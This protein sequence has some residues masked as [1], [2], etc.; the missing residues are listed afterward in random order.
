LEDLSDSDDAT[1]EQD[2]TSADCLNSGNR[3]RGETLST[4]AAS[5]VCDTRRDLSSDSEVDLAERND[6]AETQ[7][8]G[9]QI[10]VT[11]HAEQLAK[12]AYARLRVESWADLSESDDEFSP[13]AH[14]KMCR[15]VRA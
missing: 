1:E 12:H 2:I 13:K 3:A 9:K 4:S 5:S 8:M 10:E 7:A 15:G 11:S 14:I 6:P